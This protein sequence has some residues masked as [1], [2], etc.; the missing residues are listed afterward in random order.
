MSQPGH[1]TTYM[2]RRMG[3]GKV[4]DS[5]PP[6]PSVQAQLRAGATAHRVLGRIRVFG[7]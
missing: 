4:M 2:L 6:D 1:P 3:D 7:F 5:L